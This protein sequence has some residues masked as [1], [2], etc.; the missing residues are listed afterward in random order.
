[1]GIARALSKVPFTD[2]V[3]IRDTGGEDENFEFSVK[4]I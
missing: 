4:P 2:T 1:M 3:T